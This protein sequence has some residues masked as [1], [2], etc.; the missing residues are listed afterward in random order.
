MG[1]KVAKG[2]LLAF[3][4]AKCQPTPNW[5]HSGLEKLSYSDNTI[6]AGKYEVTPF[7]SK[8]IDLIYG[9][10]YLNNLK[11]VQ[12]KYGVTTGNLFVHKSM[13]DRNGYFLTDNV[14]GNDIEWT[15]RAI[16][17]KGYN[18]IYEPKAEVN[19]PGQSYKELMNSVP[20]YA[21]GIV[22]FNKTRRRSLIGH[23][24]NVTKY[25]LP[26][27]ISNFNQALKYRRLTY[28]PIRDK[29]FVWLKV[30]AVKLKIAHHYFK[31]LLN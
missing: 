12:R 13:F 1:V 3:L 19:Y 31:S 25:L 2:K 23:L 6:V 17:S 4:D 10:L 26:M 20:K 9:L 28:L 16:K 27:R 15:E 30:W 22:N 29:L 11:N 14:S 5:L 24:V 8:L 7:S 18:I 21:N